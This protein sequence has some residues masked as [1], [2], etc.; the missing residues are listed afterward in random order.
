MTTRREN[1]MK[2][3]RHETPEWIPV[4]GHCDPYNQPSREGMD[5]E[6][7]AA[8]GRGALGRRQPR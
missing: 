8:A 7:A 4:T 3:F 2:I 1:L 5:P 6:L